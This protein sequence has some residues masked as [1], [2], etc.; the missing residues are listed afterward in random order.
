MTVDLITPLIVNS[1]RK[2]FTAEKKAEAFNLRMNVVSAAISDEQPMLL[3][4]AL[5][6]PRQSTH[7]G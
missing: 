2:G 3:I 4:Q 7:A 5:V 6:M 1:A